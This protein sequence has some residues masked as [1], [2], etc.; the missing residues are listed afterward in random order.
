MKQK[1]R[2]EYID[3]VRKVMKL[4]LNG[5]NVIKAIKM[6]NMYDGLHPKSNLDR[7]YL[8]RENGGRGLI[9]VGDCIMN[10]RNNLGLYV[11]DSSE[12]FIVFA[13]RE[14]KLKECIEDGSEKTRRERRTKSWHEKTLHGQ[15]IRETEKVADKQ[16]WSWLKQGDLKRETESLIFV[17][18]EQALRTNAIKAGIDK[19][20]ISPACRMC[21]YA[22]EG[23]THITS[24]CQKL[25]QT[26]YK[27]RHDKVGKRSIGY[28]QR[29]T[30]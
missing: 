7:L 16:S 11:K 28:Y 10:Q 18:Q 22:S 6:L 25:A 23:V 19:Q 14:L 15:F 29:N 13:E 8:K 17:A 20:N 12:N 30:I 9:S 24:T 2:K 4:K 21:G 1:T 26:R 27:R 3:R 5:G